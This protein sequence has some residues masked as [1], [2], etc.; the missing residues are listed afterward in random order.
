[1]RIRYY[2]PDCRK[3]SILNAI[4]TAE[5]RVCAWCGYPINPNHVKEQIP[6]QQ[7]DLLTGLG[8]LVGSTFS[9]YWDL[10]FL[11]ILFFSARPEPLP[12][13]SWW[14]IFYLVCFCTL[15]F[16]LFFSYLLIWLL[17]SLFDV[18]LGRKKLLDKQRK[19]I[20]ESAVTDA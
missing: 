7:L 4:Y 3:K 16:A 15:L 20:N 2:C 1:M 9:G 8:S 12:W 18:N 5:P 14:S 10:I 17:T 19:E 6:Y 11:R 13:Y